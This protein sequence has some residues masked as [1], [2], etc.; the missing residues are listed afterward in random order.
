MVK[1]RVNIY[2]FHSVIRY[3]YQELIIKNTLF[4]LG[5][6][7]WRTGWAVTSFHRITSKTTPVTLS[8]SS[9]D[10]GWFLFRPFHWMDGWKT[11]WWVREDR[12]ESMLDEMKK[13]QEEERRKVGVE[14]ERLKREEE[15]WRGE[16][17]RRNGGVQCQA[18]SVCKHIILWRWLSTSALI[19]S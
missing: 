9:A 16:G 18:I 2:L 12:R 17:D 5:Y 19:P 7:D 1:D 13:R 15:R 4:S 3:Y 6:C 14:K 11:V 10:M 8:K